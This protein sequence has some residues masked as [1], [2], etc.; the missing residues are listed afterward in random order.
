MKTLVKYLASSV[1]PFGNEFGTKVYLAAD[2]EARERERDKEIIS[3]LKK[4]AQPDQG[5]IRTSEPDP[6]RILSAVLTVMN[7]NRDE[8]QRLLAQMEGT[9]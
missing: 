1:I 2:V 9:P 5:V 7:A 8:A 4:I 3:L 6:I